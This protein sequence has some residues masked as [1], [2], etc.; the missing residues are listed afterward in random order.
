MFIKIEVYNYVMVTEGFLSE[1]LKKVVLT[2]ADNLIIPLEIAKVKR[3]FSKA[4]K[5]R[6]FKKEI[7]NRN[8][9]IKKISKFTL[10]KLPSRDKILKQNKSHLNKIKSIIG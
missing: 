9:R 10:K 5:E 8:N 4:A 1:D 6:I 7:K 2:T 3:F